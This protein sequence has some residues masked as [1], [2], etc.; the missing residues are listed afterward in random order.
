M[1]KIAKKFLGLLF[2]A[3]FLIAAGPSWAAFDLFVFVEGIPGQS[4]DERHEDWIEALSF[5]N[6][7]QYDPVARQVTFGDVGM[8]KELDR[9]SVGLSAHAVAGTRIPR[10][11]FDFAYS[12]TGQLYL[13]I[14]L[15]GARIK[16][17]AASGSAIGEARPTEEVSFTFERITWQYWP[18]SGGPVKLTWDVLRNCQS[19]QYCKAD[20]DVEGDVDGENLAKFLFAFGSSAGDRNYYAPADMDA[21][22]IID[23]GDLDE[24]ASE[25]SLT[26]CIRCGF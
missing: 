16:K 22:S 11:I 6:D 13:Q 15:N 18:A 26:D 20:F 19:E 3:C 9:A 17:V 4:G 21:D 14:T 25:Y 23:E 12:S 5:K 7:I 2:F 8:V 1:R 10:V 24:F